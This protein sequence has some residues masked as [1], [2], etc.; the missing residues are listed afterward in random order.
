MKSRRLTTGDISR[1]EKVVVLHETVLH[2]WMKDAVTFGCVAALAWFNHAYMAGSWAIDLFA[3][4][5]VCTF[6]L[7]KSLG[8]ST[9]VG[10]LRDLLSRLDDAGARSAAERPVAG[11]VNT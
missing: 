3:V 6:G 1:A 7:N 11:R 8:Y 10:E 2:S 5:V 9:T 4:F